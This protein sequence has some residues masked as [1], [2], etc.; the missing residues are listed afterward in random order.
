MGLGIRI[1]RF[2]A[3]KFPVLLGTDTLREQLNRTY[4]INRRMHEQQCVNLYYEHTL[5]DRKFMDFLEKMRVLLTV[6]NVKKITGGG[7][8]Y[9][10]VGKADDGGY[11]M[12]DEF[13]EVEAVYSFGIAEDV[14][15]DRFFADKGIDVF[16]YDH[17]I[18]RLPEQNSYFHWK[19]LGLCAEGINT[20]NMKSLREFIEENGHQNAKNMVLKMDIEGYEWDVFAEMPDEILNQFS[21]ITMEI[22]YLFDYNRRENMYKALERINRT[23]QLIHIHANN[24]N[25][26]I[27]T[28]KFCYP[29]NLEVT[30]LKREGHEFEDT[31]KFFPTELDN[32]N[33]SFFPDIILGFWNEK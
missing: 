28:E 12:F 32:R 27:V 20:D 2:L 3:T 21:Q 30:Y 26:A 33:V 11:I 23:H 29:K 10:R 1:K 31:D 18:N 17:S 24:A 15:C 13:N 5:K 4:E 22:H 16:M 7:K 8:K 19:K 6:K 25:P 14:S 9:I